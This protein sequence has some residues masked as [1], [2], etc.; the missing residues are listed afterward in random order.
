MDCVQHGNLGA[1]IWMAMM[2][3]F[4]LG[5]LISGL[6]NRGKLSM[7]FVLC[8]IAGAFW[9]CTWVAYWTTPNP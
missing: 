1:G 9:A 5:A 4:V 3:V 6:F 7:F 8:M 2:G